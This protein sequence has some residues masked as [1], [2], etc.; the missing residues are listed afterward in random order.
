MMDKSERRQDVGRDV[1]ILK[2]ESLMLI[3]DLWDVDMKPVGQ[4][5]VPTW[6][7]IPQLLQWQDRYFLRIDKVGVH[8]REVDGFHYYVPEP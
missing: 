6:V 2:E 7:D 3:V 5:S 1:S 4:I 8:Y